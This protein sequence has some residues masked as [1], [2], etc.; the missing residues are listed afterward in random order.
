MVGQAGG[1]EVDWGLS[2]ANGEVFGVLTLSRDTQD[3]TQLTTGPHR[4]A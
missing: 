3:S 4:L 1:E 2:Q